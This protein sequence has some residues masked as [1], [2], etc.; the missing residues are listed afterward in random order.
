VNDALDTAARAILAAAGDYFVSQGRNITRGWPDTVRELPGEPGWLKSP[1][2]REVMQALGWREARWSNWADYHIYYVEDDGWDRRCD[3]AVCYTRKPTA[4]SDTQRASAENI[5][6]S[7]CLAAREFGVDIPYAVESDG[8]AAVPKVVGARV[9]QSGEYGQVWLAKSIRLGGHELPFLLGSVQPRDNWEPTPVVILAADANTAVDA[10]CG[11]PVRLPGFAS[12]RPVGDVIT[13]YIACNC[14]TEPLCDGT[15]GD[16][17]DGVNA[18]AIRDDLVEQIS[19]DFIGGR[20]ARARQRVHA[21][22]AWL[23]SLPALQRDLGDR[24][25]SEKKYR[26]YQTRAARALDELAGALKHE[27]ARARRAARLG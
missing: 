5:A 17:D 22:E 19:N 23:S 9:A 10:V 6:D 26:R 15:W 4:V 20:V 7:I 25:P 16:T 13:G 1:V 14:D 11:K 2:G 24:T 27:L 8:Q 21:L 3:K 12:P 18:L